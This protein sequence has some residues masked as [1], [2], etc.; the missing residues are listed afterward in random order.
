MA[1]A[2]SGEGRCPAGE[3]NAGRLAG[4]S[5]V[6]EDG[7]LRLLRGVRWLNR[8]AALERVL[9]WGTDNGARGVGCLHWYGG[10]VRMAE[11][12]REKGITE[13]LPSRRWLYERLGSVGALER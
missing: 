2:D 10:L 9:D 3:G 5:D 6:D 8:R 12:A 7:L 1:A 13:G 4:R 11:I